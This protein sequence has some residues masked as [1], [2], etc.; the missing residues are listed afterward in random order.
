DAYN[1]VVKSNHTYVLHYVAQNDGGNYFALSDMPDAYTYSSTTFKKGADVI[2]TLRNYMGD[3]DF[4]NC[5]S[6]FLDVYKFQAVTAAQ[7][8]D[9]LSACS[10]TDLTSF[11][12][13]WIYA[14]GFPAF[15]V[16]SISYF[17]AATINGICIEQKLKHAPAFFN[18]VP[19]TISF[20]DANWNLYHEE[21]VIMSGEH[22]SFS[23]PSI[24][25]PESVIIDYHE[26]ISDAVTSNEIMMTTPGDY[27]FSNAFVTI[28]PVVISDTAIIYG[29]QYWVEGDNYKE[30]IPG[31]HVNTQRYWKF[32]GMVP[33][34]FQAEAT[35]KYNGKT[36]VSGGNQD[37]EFISNIEDSLVLLYRPDASSDWTIYPDYTLNDLGPNNDKF[38]QFELSAFML[39]EYALGMYNTSLP[40]EA[41]DE[42]EDCSI[43]SVHELEEVFF[44]IYPNPAQHSFNIKFKNV[45]NYKIELFD[46]LG[47]KIFEMKPSS[48]AILEIS[49]KELAAG[50]Y[51]IKCTSVDNK[52]T[53]TEKL[54]IIR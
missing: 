35:I 3:D 26:K 27:Y 41:S 16:E 47:N 18:D 15:E 25:A 28:S 6:S 45:G 53:A 5:I 10:G 12:D 14:A 36:G 1:E 9:H 24:P 13:N 38:G 4:F 48:I 32:Q 21:S 31:L 52:L 46:S 37:N 49:T 40:D 2:A 50:S 8:K 42:I 43:V 22:S 33:G 39:G 23:F 51:E 44:N 7:L 17:D 11:F 29:Q 30:V 20:F 19:L 54:V 34:D